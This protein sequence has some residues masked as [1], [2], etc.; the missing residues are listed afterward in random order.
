MARSAL[1][2]S[3]PAS[4]LAAA[5]ACLS[6]PAPRPA[7]V[8]RPLGAAALAAVAALFAAGAVIFGPEPVRASPPAQATHA[9]APTPPDR[10]ERR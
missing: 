8:L 5:R 9:D 10:P 4:D 2:T 3:P 1:L 6:V 7:S